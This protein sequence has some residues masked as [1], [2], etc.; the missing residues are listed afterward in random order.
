MNAYYKGQLMIGPRGPAGPDGGPIGTIISYMGRSAPQDY[1]ICDGAEHLITDYP[2]LAAFFRE[3]FGAVNHFGGDGET[4]FAVPDMRNLFL[5]GYHG[6]AEDQLSGE[7]G[8]KQ[9]GTVL[10]YI[11]TGETIAFSRLQKPL[12]TD[13][14]GKSVPANNKS[15]NNTNTYNI[16]YPSNYT[17]RPVNTA[18]LYCIKAAVS[19]PVLEEYDTDGGWHVRKWSDGYVEM[20]VT[21]HTTTTYAA[22]M[23]QYFTRH[24]I[25]EIPEIPIPLLK[26]YKD[27][28][29]LDAADF[30]GWLVRDQ[31]ILRIMMGAIKT[32]MNAEITREVTGR[33]K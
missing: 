3:Q 24:D 11:W 12:H 18:V 30:L 17:A 9:E 32:K 4:T 19:G 14:E 21:F 1:L 20:T 27:D 5:R 31:G 7:I 22:D 16:E 25:D 33:W 29:C 23:N 13:S 28:F 15:V 10:P 8:E 2:D 6:N 26:T